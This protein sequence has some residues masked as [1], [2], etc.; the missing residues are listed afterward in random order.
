MNTIEQQVSIFLA[1]YMFLAKNETK[2]QMLF[3]KA[4]ALY[5]Y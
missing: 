5:Q 1:N 3:F 2:V 4:I